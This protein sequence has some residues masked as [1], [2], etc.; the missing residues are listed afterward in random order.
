MIILAEVALPISRITAILVFSVVSA[1]LASNLTLSTRIPTLEVILLS[2]SL[3]SECWYN[4]VLY[5][6]IEANV[7]EENMP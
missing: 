3:N 5:T 4:T 1:D 2:T 7:C 6:H